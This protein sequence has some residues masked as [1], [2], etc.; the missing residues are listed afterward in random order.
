MQNVCRYIKEKI[1][2]AEKIKFKNKKLEV[3]KI[4][5]IIGY[6]SYNIILRNINF[7]IK[8]GYKI[9]NFIYKNIQL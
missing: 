5:S 8:F 6:C 9:C 1:K 7:R 4:F 3:S 2:E